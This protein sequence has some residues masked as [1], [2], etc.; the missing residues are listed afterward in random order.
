[1][2]KSCG[3]QAVISYLKVTKMGLWS[4]LQWRFTKQSLNFPSLNLVFN[5]FEALLSGQFP[6]MIKILTLRCPF[7]VHKLLKLSKMSSDF[8]WTEIIQFLI[9][10]SERRTENELHTLLRQP[11][12]RISDLRFSL[13]CKNICTHSAV[14]IKFSCSK[15]K[16]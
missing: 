1:M 11:T 10:Q 2:W 13:P 9:V 15:L 12:S 16:Q 5:R 8:V 14:G 7:K 4:D 6:Y 3:K